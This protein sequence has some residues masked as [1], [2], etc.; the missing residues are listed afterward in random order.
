M[1][2]MV[3]LT[4]RQNTNKNKSLI[5]FC[6][7]GACGL[8]AALAF[9]AAVALALTGG[10]FGQ[11][12]AE[13]REAFTKAMAECESAA[14][15]GDTSNLAIEACN[16]ALSADRVPQSSLARLRSNRGVILLRRG[17]TRLAINDLQAASQL[18]SGAPEIWLNLS[19]AYAQSGDYRSTLQTARTALE[20]GINQPELAHFNMAIAFENLERWDDAYAQYVEAASLAPDNPTL[21][22]QPGRFQRHR[23]Q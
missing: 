18:D 20:L 19:A 6:V 5:S 14:F 7:G 4:E 17:D 22:A 9:S 12:S 15:S 23:D 16:F 21:Q 2:G 10:A 1:K 8:G 13:D 3:V 11:E